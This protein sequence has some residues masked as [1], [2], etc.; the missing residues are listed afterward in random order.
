MNTAF[1]LMAEYE[2]S[3]IPL[4]VIAEKYLN[5]T[6]RTEIQR[7]ARAQQFPFAVYRAKSNASEWIVHVHD[8]ANWI[9]NQ[10]EEA[11]KSWAAIN[12]FNVKPL[13][14]GSR[15]SNLCTASKLPSSRA[16]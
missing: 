8:L 10:R 3:Q 7:K 15:A 9:D 14:P 16:T 1:L 4:T 2:T 12:G 13:T 5:I 11:A 6:V